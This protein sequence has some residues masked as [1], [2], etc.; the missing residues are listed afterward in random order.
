MD[1]VAEYHALDPL[2][3]FLKGA[4]FQFMETAKDAFERDPR[5]HRLGRVSL[6]GNFPTLVYDGTDG[7][8][9]QLLVT[10]VV[11][12]DGRVVAGIKT[13]QGKK[14]YKKQFNPSA[15]MP[16]S[17]LDI[18][19]DYLVTDEELKREKMATEVID[20]TPYLGKH[21]RLVQLARK[22]ILALAQTRPQFY[23]AQTITTGVIR[24]FF[25]G[26]IPNL[27]D[28]MLTKALYQLWETRGPSQSAGEEISHI[29]YRYGRL[30]SS[31]VSMDVALIK[32]AA[33]SV[34]LLKSM[35]KPM[36]ASYANALFQKYLAG[37]LAGNPMPTEQVSVPR[38]SPA[39]IF[40]KHHV[41]GKGNQAQ[42]LILQIGDKDIA[43]DFAVSLVSE[44]NWHSLA[45][46][47]KYPGL[48]GDSPYRELL[49][50]TVL[51]DRYGLTDAVALATRMFL[52]LGDKDQA[53]ILVKAVVD[54]SGDSL[55]EE[56]TMSQWG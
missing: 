3:E 21:A 54:D 43:R 55:I 15:L 24:E 44:V 39:S 42:R 7:A 51:D 52:I 2:Q 26:G 17:L 46:K 30:L 37:G 1:K 27:R 33:F 23:E 40:M 36:L 20:L 47:L 34:L 28:P 5:V 18:L 13:P 9:E 4:S 48:S 56:D 12:M 41:E 16:L 8:G 35:K 38:V 45:R 25:A 22:E 53:Q 10:F 31:G 49:R 14:T 19:Y 11:Y 29:A 32:A 50:T 6:I